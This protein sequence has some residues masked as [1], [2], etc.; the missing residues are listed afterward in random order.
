MFNNQKKIRKV[1]TVSDVLEAHS[2]LETFLRDYGYSNLQV[3]ELKECHR[4]GLI[5]DEDFI[6][7]M[8]KYDLDFDERRMVNK[9]KYMNQCIAYAEYMTNVLKID[10]DESMQSSQ[11]K[12][13]GSGESG[14]WSI[15]PYVEE[16]IKYRFN[17]ALLE[18][19]LRN[20]D[21]DFFD[22]EVR[23]AELNSD[24]YVAVLFK[25]EDSSDS[26]KLSIDARFNDSFVQELLKR[27][28][29]TPHYDENENLIKDDIV[30]QWFHTAIIVMAAN[31]LKESDLDIFRSVS[32]DNPAVPL[33]E[34]LEFDTDELENLSETE[35][36]QIQNIEKNGRLYR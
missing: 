11:H 5:N 19:E 3:T 6:D 36:Q 16:N 23:M 24:P 25:P 30:E 18:L 26:S 31:M 4:K 29:Y 35:R 28:E 34:K 10:Y 8:G 27:D 7:Y 1:K 9:I 20:G 2:Q 13:L 22:Y 15:D 21:I 32:A 33:I 17:K 14:E 12:A